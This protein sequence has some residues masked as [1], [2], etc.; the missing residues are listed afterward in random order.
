MKRLLLAIVLLLIIAPVYAKDFAVQNNSVTLF[1]ITGALGRIFM[2]P[3]GGLVGI[4]T[5]NP[6]AKLDI[7]GTNTANNLSLSVNGTLYVNSSGRVGI[8]T[9]NPTSSLQVVGDTNVT[10]T[11]YAT[12]FIGDGSLLA[13]V[14]GGTNVSILYGANQSN[15][16][17]VI[18]AQI[19]TAG[20]LLISIAE[21]TSTGWSSS[22]S[23]VF[24][25]TLTNLVGIGTANPSAGLQINTSNPTLRTN[26][27]AIFDG[28]VGI[29]VTSPNSK[30]DVSGN[31]SISG[32]LL[33]NGVNISA[34]QAADNTTNAALLGQ[35]V[36]IT[37]ANSNNN[38]IVGLVGTKVNNSGG[39]YNGNFTFNGLTNIGLIVNSANNITLNVSSVLLVNGSSAGAIEV[40]QANLS[41]V[42]NPPSNNSAMER[43]VDSAGKVVAT[44]FWN[45][46]ALVL[47]VT[48]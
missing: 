18:P 32:T 43:W 7:T 36:N 31:A 28:N 20:N 34:G 15:L 30:L 25:T 37:D 16:T 26:G 6:Q 23:F 17:Q 33:V 14:T 5:T 44:R 48:G 13:G 2:L 22:G 42:N 8:N 9:T 12:T 27:S 19:S 40:R 4:G 35:K 47:N 24:L 10:G 21:G 1:N 39:S 45:G 29:G 11:V 3:L 38:T 41:F 46:T